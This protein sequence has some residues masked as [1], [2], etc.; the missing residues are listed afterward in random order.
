MPA[1]VPSFHVRVGNLNPIL[2]LLQQSL[3]LEPSPQ[4]LTKPVGFGSAIQL[5]WSVNDDE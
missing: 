3:L 4:S 2:V 5:Y 1:T